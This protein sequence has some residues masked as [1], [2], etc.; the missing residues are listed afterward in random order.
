MSR[1]TT[2]LAWVQTLTQQ[3]SWACSCRFC[4]EVS[5]CLVCHIT[6]HHPWDVVKWWRQ[7]ILTGFSY[8][9]FAW[10]FK[11]LPY[12]TCQ[13]WKELFL[14]LFWQWNGCQLVGSTINILESFLWSLVLVFSGGAFKSIWLISTQHNSESWHFLKC[15][16][17]WE[18]TLSNH[19]WMSGWGLDIVYW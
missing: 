11:V 19:L 15:L 1:G 14:L 17:M 2:L 4:T 10:L 6:G 8:D 5:N 16:Q 9:C 13:I 12:K 3:T 7:R 18:I